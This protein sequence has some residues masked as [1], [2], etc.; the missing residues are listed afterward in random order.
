MKKKDLFSHL[1]S[2]VL[3]LMLF[4]TLKAY[5]LDYTITFTG[6]GASTTV[7]S[8][9]VQNLTK[10][11]IVT[12]PT[13]NVLNLSD[14]P[15]A[16]ELLNEDDETIRI[17]PDAVEGK[18]TVSFFA[19]QAGSTQL[20]A[21]SIDGRKIAGITEN[22]QIGI[23]SFQL[24]LPKGSF[25]I[26]VVG[27]GYAYTA[28]MI[29][30]TGS[31]RKP[32]VSYNGTVKLATYNPQKSKNSA[33][34]ITTMTYTTGDQLLY[35]G[36]SGNYS[37]IVTDVPTASKTINFDF[38]TCAD[39]DGNNYTTVTIGTQTWMVENL[40][41]TKYSDGTAIPM[42]TDNSAW[43]N[44]S[45]PAYCWYN[46][47]E[48][49][50]KNTYGA[51]YNRSAVNTSKLA[52]A[53]W[54]VPTDAEWTTLTTYL[55][56]ES[57]AGG[58]LKEVGTDNWSSPNIGATNV[59]GFS[60][61]PG[62]GRGDSGGRFFRIG[63]YGSW[64][65]T[66]EYDASNPWIRV[67]DNYS[68]SLSR[69]T[70]NLYGYGTNG[71]S[72]R[73]VKDDVSSIDIQK[74][75]IPAGTFTMGSPES[76][77]DRISDETQHAVTLSA[78]RMSKYEITNEQYAV[79]LNTKGIGSNG[80]YAAGAYPTDTMI[81]VNSISYDWGLHYNGT[82][83]ISAAGYENNP[84]IN[85]TWY[86]ATEFAICIGGSLPTEAQWE[87]ACRAG[88]PTPF[89]TGSCLTNMQANYIWLYPYNS[90]TN[91]ITTSP[92]KTQPVGT[93]TP[94]DFGLYDMHGNVSEWCSDWY[95]DYPST[96]QTNPIGAAT[97]S[98]RVYRG[99]NLDEYARN[100]RSADRTNSSPSVYGYALG[101]RV[102]FV[103]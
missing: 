32:E 27:N 41:T 94:N 50:N 28:K 29:N 60:A 89:N 68:S 66:T 15:N 75:N 18:F 22:L 93:Y 100:C 26:Q 17:Y 61:L 54:H 65:S 8:V 88:T 30:Q 4:V 57:V 42:V 77:F 1:I 45:T 12:V 24:S 71:F 51:L 80:L 79:F 90:C 84:V 85:V 9:I 95:G 62:G 33:P 10:G 47:D 67:L 56:G 74:V 36:I 49:T 20:N 31:V 21:F 35:K 82:Q 69:C 6:T 43:F 64:W 23:N 76:E 44:L 34:S 81:Y 83:W 53:G 13:G 96:A 72:V 99:G 19:K 63:N 86:G 73:C 103:P 11:T 7:S 37:T 98:Y 97:G 91:T 3:F 14:A 48:A 38:V 16:V 46:N 52:P 55:G 40:K 78:F 25:V 39:A 102:V 92:E 70:N 58:K 101:F 59:S 5:A 2:I 87:Y